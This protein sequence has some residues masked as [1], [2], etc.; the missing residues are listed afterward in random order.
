MK[1]FRLDVEIL[2]QD[3]VRIIHKLSDESLARWMKDDALDIIEGR[4]ERRFEA[5]GDDASGKWAPLTHDTQRI[6]SSQGYMPDHPILER[7]GELR[8]AVLTSKGN[9]TVDPSGVMLEWPGGINTPDN[10]KHIAYAIA[11]K[12]SLPNKTV[13]RP[14]AAADDTDMILLME[15]LADEL[16]EGFF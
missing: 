14:I 5:E 16:F 8:E 13:S 1:E 12:G 3:I 9:L 15:S 4:T 2:D 7:S 6:R 10:S 11:Q